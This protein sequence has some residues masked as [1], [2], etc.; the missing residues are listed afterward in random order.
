[1]TRSK[2]LLYWTP[3]VLGMIAA[4]FLGLFALDVFG[5]GHGVW[6]TVQ[7]FAIHL[8]PSA[9]VLAAV[10]IAWRW[11]VAGGILFIL[12]GVGY[13]FMVGPTRHPDWIAMIAGPLWL[14]GALFLASRAF[15]A[16]APAGSGQV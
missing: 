9:V 8:L 10:A 4:G 15:H 7:A 3:R 13:I 2:P 16:G 11:E 1:M 12:A 14:V 6:G 5:E